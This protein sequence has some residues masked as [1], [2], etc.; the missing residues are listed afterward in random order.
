[1]QVVLAQMQQNIPEWK[2]CGCNVM[3]SLWY[4]L[5]HAENSTQRFG[6]VLQ[7]AEYI[8]KLIQRLQESPE[9]VLADFESVRK[10]GVAQ[11]PLS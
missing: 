3:Y 5:M 7:R 11:L 6:Y 2:R 9:E 4:D 1:M 8:P 10:H